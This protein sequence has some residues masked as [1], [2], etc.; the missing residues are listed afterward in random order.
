[1]NGMKKIKLVVVYFA[2]MA[3]STLKP[4]PD[5][6]GYTHVIVTREQQVAGCDFLLKDAADQFYEPLNLAADYKVD[7]KPIYIKYHYEKNMAST[8]MKG[9]IITIT[10]YL[11]FP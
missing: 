1:M 9:K 3:C 7:G 8:C 4:N 5:T 2:C 11:T 6:S 10:D